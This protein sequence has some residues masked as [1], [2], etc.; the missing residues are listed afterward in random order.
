MKSLSESEIFDYISQL[1]ADRRSDLIDRLSQ[2]HE[3]GPE[4]FDEYMTDRRF[5]KGRMCPYCKSNRVVRYGKTDTGS[6]RYMCRKCHRTFNIRTGTILASSKEPLD[7]WRRY[8]SC[9]MNGYTIKMC[10][11]DCGI[12]NKTAFDWRHR[13][14]DALS[15]YNDDLVLDGIV[16]ADEAYS[17][18]SF[19]G[20]HTEDN[21]FESQKKRFNRDESKIKRGI[22][23]Q[24]VCMPFAID[25]TGKLYSKVSNLGR[26]TTKDLHTTLDGHIAKGSTLVT[27]KHNAYCRFAKSNELEHVQIK[28][29]KTK[30][31]IYNIQRV[32]SSHSKF[33][34]FMSRFNG[35]ASKYLN[36]YLTWNDTVSNNK[37]TRKDG[38]D[39]LMAKAF[40]A[41][42]HET[43]DNISKRPLIPI[44]SEDTTK[45]T[46][47]AK[48]HPGVKQEK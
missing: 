38:A 34:K 18:I 12:S 23:D 6:Q 14:L 7:V 48:Q 33:R 24:Q 32:N 20:N 4:S 27:D 9:M 22:S 40:V 35:T 16:E 41:D 10:C 37:G 17:R 11:E 28:G 44:G 8:V 13:I 29:G 30:K 3:S 39:K 43:R 42:L 47:S 26:P 45:K 46:N 25:R 19:A 2:L 1:P 15:T 36:N 21:K 31:G 5:A